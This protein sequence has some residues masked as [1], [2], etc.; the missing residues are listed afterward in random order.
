MD[1]LCQAA[2]MKRHRNT[3]NDENDPSLPEP[4]SP[5]RT[6][7]N[8]DLHFDTPPLKKRYVT[9]DVFCVQTSCI[10]KME[11]TVEGTEKNATSS[12]CYMMSSCGNIVIRKRFTCARGPV[13]INMCSGCKNRPNRHQ[14]CATPYYIHYTK[15]K[16]SSSDSKGIELTPKISDA[17][18]TFCPSAAAWK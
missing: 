3:D 17:Y 18:N 13:Q 15:T 4:N 7:N 10:H 8:L 14:P 1:L 6:I 11:T 12:L 2:Q 16:P 9:I 5:T